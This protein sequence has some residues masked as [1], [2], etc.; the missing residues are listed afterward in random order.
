M[1]REAGSLPHVI[2]T[3]VSQ[4]AEAC[5]GTVFSPRAR[6]T[7]HTDS[8]DIMTSDWR[9]PRVG[10]AHPASPFIP[11]PR[12]HVAR[13]VRSAPYRGAVWRIVAVFLLVWTQAAT[14]G[15]AEDSPDPPESDRTVDLRLWVDSTR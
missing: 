9:G 7:Q 6:C 8:L 3:A 4:L 10:E 14:P 5:D 11:N 1:S 12:Y 15:W 2:V 13:S